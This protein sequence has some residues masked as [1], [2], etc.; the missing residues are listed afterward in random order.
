[1]SNLLDSFPTLN[2]NLIEKS[3]YKIN[4]IEVSY[5]KDGI[6]RKLQL[7]PINDKQYVLDDEYDSWMPIKDNLNINIQCAIL[8]KNT[9]FN[10]EYGLANKKSKLGI[11]INYY[12]RKTN[13]NVSEKIAEVKYDAR[14]PKLNFSINL[15]FDKGELADKIGIKILLY[16]DKSY[17][18]DMFA[19]SSGAILGIYSQLEIFIEG[20]GSIFPIKISD[21][22]NKPL[23]FAEFNFSDISEEL[24]EE[25]NVCLYL[26]KA[27]KDYKFLSAEGTTI[28][29]LMKEIISEFIALFIDD[30]I[31][32]ENIENICSI[33][34]EEEQAIG[35]VAKYW[36]KFFNI[37]ITNFNDMLYSIKCAIDNLID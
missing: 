30:I 22:K 18:N 35:N 34:Y 32:K 24:F 23:W 36:L 8:D 4:Q 5:L 28:S 2:E 33:D 31:H 37:E 27:H 19:S 20:K 13:K 6:K 3:G 26:N 9:L 17:E 14:E 1:M 7:N 25:N 10:E 21:D 12:C 15:S 29:P 16:L 11:A